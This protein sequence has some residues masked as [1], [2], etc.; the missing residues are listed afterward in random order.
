MRDNVSVDTDYVTPNLDKS[1]YAIVCSALR[2]HENS[3]QPHYPL[4]LSYSNR[5]N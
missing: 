1:F 3:F 5:S 4:T 2:V